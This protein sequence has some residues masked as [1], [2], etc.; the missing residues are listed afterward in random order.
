MGIFLIT[1]AEEVY[2]LV[3]PEGELSGVYTLSKTDSPVDVQGNITLLPGSY[4]N[5]TEGVVVNVKEGCW[6]E[7]QGSLNV[8]GTEEEPVTILSAGPG[9]FDRINM[10]S[11]SIA[12]LDH[13]NIDQ[14]ERGL[15]AYGSG[16]IVHLYNSTVGSENNGVTASS[17]S[18]V[19]SINTTYDA[20]NRFSV[21]GA[22]I[23]EG[24]WFDFRAVRDTNGAGVPSVQVRV[25]H[26]KGSDYEFEEW[27]VF[28]SVSNGIETGPDGRLPPIPVDKFKHNGFVSSLPVNMTMKWSHTN[29][30]GSTWGKNLVDEGM[31]V[32]DNFYMVWEMD[33]TP[34]PAPTNL[35]G[36]N[37]SDTWV[38]LEWDQD[39]SADLLE[40][41]LRYK[42]EWEMEFGAPT[43]FGKGIQPYRV[44]DLLPETVYTFRLQSMDFHPNHSNDT[45]AHIRTLDIEPPSPP[46]DLRIRSIG[47]DWSHLEWSSSSS[48]DVTGYEIEM[49]EVGGD[50]N[51]TFFEHHYMNLS[52]NIS[53]LPSET[54]FQA[55][56]R[57]FDDA[58]DPNPSNWTEWIQFT[59]S[60]VTSPLTPQI[61]L[62][63]MHAVQLVPGN[64]F[65]NTT[66][67]GFTI[68]VPE[69]NRTVLEIM[70][71]G[72][73]YE[74]PDGNIERWT[75]FNGQLQYFLSLDP[76][77]HT[78]KVRSI[79]PS[80]NAGPYNQTSFVIDKTLPVIDSDIPR[81]HIHTASFGESFILSVNATD[82][83]GIHL[84]KWTLAEED[85]MEYF[86][87]P[88]VEFDLEI[89][90]YTVRI[91]AYDIAG[92]WADLVF[93]LVVEL[94]DTEAPTVKGHHPQDGDVDVELGPTITIE[95]SEKI[96]WS[97]VRITL[98]TSNGG[99][100]IDIS[101]SYMEDQNTITCYPIDALDDDTE[102]LLTLT[103][104]LDPSGNDGGPFSFTF[105]T[106][107]SSKMD[108][109]NDGIPDDI[110]TSN[111]FLSPS[112]P[113]DADEDEDKDGLTNVEEYRRNTSMV[114]PD[115]DGDGMTDGWEVQYDLDPLDNTDATGDEDRD[116][117]TNLK[118]FE[119]GTDPTDPES[120]PEIKAEG[121]ALF[122]VVSILLVVLLLVGM[123]VFLI[124]MVR[125]KKREAEEEESLERVRKDD[126]PKDSATWSEEEKAEKVECRECGAT[127][128]VS[129]GY[130][131][132]CGAIVSDDDVDGSI[133][134]EDETGEGLPPMM[135]DIGS[136]S[137]EDGESLPPAMPVQMNEEVLDNGMGP[138]AMEEVLP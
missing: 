14:T 16:T 55:R 134:E 132:E 88:E 125:K 118:E 71:D 12:Y 119:T 100:D 114:D 74:D 101:I 82:E 13:V 28:D 56:M 2:G 115:S 93:D 10:T 46:T 78:L 59:T 51:F 52:M 112:D 120:K 40:Y 135:D 81:G 121:T 90:N 91:L 83:N 67:I 89:G 92:N 41:S 20:N 113:S 80:G 4:L 128:D 38:D 33:F 94:P 29:E 26:R 75:T 85:Y 66:L 99:N 45:I 98:K 79:D 3:I 111:D 39:P 25:N 105:T 42:K 19:W 18:L 9:S 84:I 21:S 24:F 53:G 73:E 70:V 123:V 76:G 62:Y 72:T 127:L 106:I 61:V 35:R 130:C 43:S 108:T 8:V 22:V 7:I 54:D 129:I 136:M 109:D 63:P 34:P 17:S 5:I 15:N 133:M 1:P 27:T 30:T 110:E 44:F 107:S 137:G 69:E 48:N 47:G 102:Y 95:L 87:G 126:G 49:E 58:V 96:E 37:V 57:A 97:S 86:F 50:L 60:D 117:Y 103:N 116:G 65:F 68:T 32:V 122:I 104:L 124:I 131:P 138:P 31:L 64:N 11:G 77:Y 36:E 6:I 23:H